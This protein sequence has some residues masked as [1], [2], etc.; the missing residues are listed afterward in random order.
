M[1][2]TTH[3]HSFTRQQEFCYANSNTKCDDVDVDGSSDFWKQYFS[4]RPT[5]QTDLNNTIP[6][7]NDQAFVSK[8]TY[9]NFT[10]AYNPV[11]PSTCRLDGQSLSSNTVTESHTE[12]YSYQGRVG[13]N[14][15][16]K[17][18]VAEV[19][20]GV[21]TAARQ[22]HALAQASWEQTVDFGYS[23]STGEATAKLSGETS[24]CAKTGFATAPSQP[25]ITAVASVSVPM[26]PDDPRCTVISVILRRVK[27]SGS[28]AV[29]VRTKG[30]CV[31]DGGH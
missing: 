1:V 31:A 8:Q 29:F 24:T 10:C 5:L 16:I 28:M 18:K 6:K 15:K 7:L 2:A 17:G 22:F 13:F 3:M 27:Q 26:T 20:G 19:R 23:K 25:L 30:W 12:T 14:M 11:A 4:A 21:V 9:R